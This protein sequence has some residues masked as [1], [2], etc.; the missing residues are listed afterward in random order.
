MPYD[1]TYENESI[2]Y[3][4][5]RYPDFVVSPL[6][7]CLTEGVFPHPGSPHCDW[8]YRYGIESDIQIDAINTSIILTKI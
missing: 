6:P 7:E 2:I 8:Y 4:D 5:P 3:L 1:W